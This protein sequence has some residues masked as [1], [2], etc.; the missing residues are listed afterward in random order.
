MAFA[1]SAKMLKAVQVFI[2]T[3]FDLCNV[4]PELWSRVNISGTD[5]LD[6][7]YTCE[8]ARQMLAGSQAAGPPPLAFLALLVTW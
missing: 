4:D 8:Y 6:V 1:V 2:T 5:C 3:F 7:C